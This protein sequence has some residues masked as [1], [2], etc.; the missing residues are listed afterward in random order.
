MTAHDLVSDLVSDLTGHG[1]EPRQPHAVFCALRAY[2]PA[3]YE[4]Q[5]CLVPVLTEREGGCS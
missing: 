1:P 3:S 4:Q 5:D 2:L